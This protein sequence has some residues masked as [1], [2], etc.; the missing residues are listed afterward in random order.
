MILTKV[1][2]EAHR[3]ECEVGALIH[4]LTP[5]LTVPDSSLPLDCQRMPNIEGDIS[6]EARQATINVRWLV[7]ERGR[8][9]CQQQD[10][11]HNH[12]DN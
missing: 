1:A 2:C 7:A 9:D 4:V 10:C 3:V 6:L 8:C 12:I 5:E 11:F